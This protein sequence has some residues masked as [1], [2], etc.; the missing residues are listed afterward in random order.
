MIEGFLR[1]EKKEKS[2][3]HTE[4]WNI[5]LRPNTA[6]I[7]METTKPRNEFWLTENEITKGHHCQD[8]ITKTWW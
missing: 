7:K 6:Q 5:L 1:K 3:C 4:V 2:R 8:K